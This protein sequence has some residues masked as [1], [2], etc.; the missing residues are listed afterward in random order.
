M[1]EIEVKAP[2]QRVLAR[3]ERKFDAK[4]DELL[5]A[6]ERELRAM[7]Q[8]SAYQWG[9]IIGEFNKALNTMA[10]HLAAGIRSVK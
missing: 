1:T 9:R 6:P 10:E 7:Q 4:I 8:S 5:P 3:A 2:I